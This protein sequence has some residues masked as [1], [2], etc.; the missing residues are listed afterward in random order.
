MEQS[1]TFGLISMEQS[2]RSL[3]EDYEQKQREIKEFDYNNLNDLQIETLKKFGQEKQLISKIAVA[4]E[5]TAMSTVRISE[6]ERN[7]LV[8]LTS[9][10]EYTKNLDA[11][12]G[13]R[14]NI[15]I[16]ALE[17]EL[18]GNSLSSMESKADDIREV[19]K[20]VNN[21][22][23]E[24]DLKLEQS[25]PTVLTVADAQLAIEKTDT[26]LNNLKIDKSDL[27][28]LSENIID[29]L[30]DNRMEGKAFEVES[31][32]NV[33]EREQE[34]DVG[35]TVSNDGYIMNTDSV[36]TAKTEKLY[37]ELMR[38]DATNES[39]TPVAKETTTDPTRVGGNVKLETVNENGSMEIEE[40]VPTHYEKE[41]INN[42]NY[43]LEKQLEEAKAQQEALQQQRMYEEQ[44][45]ELRRQEEQKNEEK[46]APSMSDIAVGVVATTVAMQ[47]AKEIEKVVIA[48]ATAK[49]NEK[50][51][52]TTDTGKNLSKSLDNKIK[53][54]RFELER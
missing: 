37:A 4:Y 30:L 19:V 17:K 18:E 33:K 52:K 3:I 42:N 36:V 45:A 6:G 21:F 47:G 50:T 39:I 34:Y 9:Y 7:S 48:E 8:G 20:T 2:V 54:S 24:N 43:E 26:M 31:K 35:V 25:E 15:V 12:T 1:E 41:E 27:D 23:V 5:A 10:E 49:T 32:E 11:L 13:G 16:S 22:A 38:E 46:N 28:N 40:R 29:T 14:D 51:E 53:K 44:Q